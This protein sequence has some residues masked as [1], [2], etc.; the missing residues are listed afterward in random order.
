MSLNSYYKT[1]LRAVFQ[2]GRFLRDDVIG[3]I[4][5]AFSASDNP[6]SFNITKV[7]RDN[8]VLTESLA[9]RFDR[10]LSETGLAEDQ[11]IIAI[12]KAAIDE[13]EARDGDAAALGEAAIVNFGK[14]AIDLGI[15][16]ESLNAVVAYV[17]TITEDASPVDVITF[18]VEKQ[19]YDEAFV[20]ESIALQLIAM[21]YLSLDD[22]G[23]A[24]EI[25][26]AYTRKLVTDEATGADALVYYQQSY[27]S[28]RYF[29][30]DYVI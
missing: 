6:P 10:A 14:R 13:A 17:R 16:V 24:S 26:K 12:A 9:R 21:N 20:A 2:I 23:T 30:T 7:L 19:L 1:G 3:S 27:V 29:A 25:A 15:A 5:D 22:S 11:D 28:E 8:A 4:A 18:A